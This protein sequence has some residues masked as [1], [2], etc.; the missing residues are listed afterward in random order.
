MRIRPADV[1]DAIAVFALLSQTADGRPP[2]RA[3]FGHHYEQLIA[4]MTYDDTDFLVADRD[5]EVVGYVLAARVL[6][7]HAAGPVSQLLE[8]VVAPEHRGQG[9]GGMLVDAVVRRARRAGAVEV[10]VVARRIPG[11]FRRRGFTETATCLTLP[12]T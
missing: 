6:S 2:Q 12:L 4:A 5:G 1:T 10:N 8:L 9:I 11:Y 7:L 3:A